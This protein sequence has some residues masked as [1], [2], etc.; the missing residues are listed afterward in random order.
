MKRLLASLLLVGAPWSQAA[1][2]PAA[3]AEPATATETV[4]EREATLRDLE[5]RT[6]HLQKGRQGMRRAMVDM[7]ADPTI[8]PQVRQ[9]GCEASIPAM[10]ATEFFKYAR[11]KVKF[12][13]KPKNFALLAPEQVERL[14]SLKTSLAALEAEPDFDCSKM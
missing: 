9:I 3:A 10:R 7:A 13:E 8:S 11:G 14:N 6:A 12:L 2:A 4:D 1:D 5:N